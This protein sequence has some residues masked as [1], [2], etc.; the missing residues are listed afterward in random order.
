MV[1]A[2]SRGSVR[3]LVAFVLLA[4]S[5]SDRRSGGTE[6][7][8]PAQA[9]APTARTLRGGVTEWFTDRAR[10]S[11]LDFVHFNGMTGRFH[12]PEVIPPGV[13]LLDYDDDGDLDVFVVQ[14][15]MLGKRPLSDALSQ[16][17]VPLKSRLYRN[18]LEVHADRARTL[19]FTDVTDAS[20]IEV[21]GYAMGAAT[22]DF[23]NDGC[24]DLY[25][26]NLER[27]Q[28]FRNNCDGTFTDVSSESRAEDRGWS[29]S[30]SFVDY[31]RDGWLDLFVG[32]YVYYSVEADKPCLHS[33]GSLVDYCPPS[34]YRP[35]PDHLYRNNR[36]GTF[37]DV[38]TAAGMGREF[39]PALGVST[40]DFNDD[41]WVDIYVAN[42]GAPN[43][44]WI[45]RHD[46]TFTNTGLLAGVALGADGEAKGSMGVDAADFDHDGDE[47]LFVT[48]LARE[49]HDLYV[50]D[51]SGV[52]AER[53]AT[54][55]IRRSS[56]PYTGFG[57][58]WFDF[59]NDGWLDIMTV[60][61]AVR[62]T[63]EALTRNE[64]FALQQP[65]QLFRNLGNGQFADVTEQAGA[66]LRSPDI[67]RGAAFG[68]IDNDGDTDVVVANDNGPIRLL[69]NN[70]GHTSHWIG[71]RLL[72][73]QKR[74]IVGARVGIVRPSTNARGASSNV[75]G[76]AKAPTLR[77]RARADGSYAS[78]N[79]PR[80]LIG[81]GDTTT[82]DKVR[83]EWPDGHAEEWT[84]VPV[85][86]YTTLKEGEGR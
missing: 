28:L 63:A 50:N 1:A 60:N 56:L 45:N 54:A 73:R 11:G 77:R 47:D 42:D 35:Q 81:L 61:G 12:F 14:G 80:V 65:K 82:I 62:H 51:G 48:E 10:E 64:T 5:C 59:D 53:A 36:D 2:L 34:V 30:A 70:I 84:D 83:V 13:A 75:E 37:T 17:Q 52:F 6:H 7:P 8:N 66:V 58:A 31:D 25:V 40:A 20:G 32:N 23:N 46:G 29:V 4:T 19:R 78:A 41:G 71:V 68:D 49:G 79:D 18:D 26:T 9:A 74:D 33:I 44:L 22:G 72:G 3:G 86:R 27:S 57:A 21:Q 67:S 38:T 85:D 55:G 24:V 69:I 16:P 76:R 15:Q 39:G 43:Q